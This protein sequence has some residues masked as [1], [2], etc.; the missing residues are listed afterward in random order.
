MANT[1]MFVVGLVFVAA[2]IW[3]AIWAI[4]LAFSVHWVLGLIV[5][6][7]FLGRT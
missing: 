2:L 3:F 1:L 7:F 4:G 6:C 5:V